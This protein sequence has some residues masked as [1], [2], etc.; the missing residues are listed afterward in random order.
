[1]PLNTINAIIDKADQLAKHWVDRT[2][3]QSLHGKRLGI[4]VDDTGW[5]Y[6]AAFD[7]SVKAMGGMSVLPI[8]GCTTRF[9][10]PPIV[11]FSHHFPCGC[12]F[13]LGNGELLRYKTLTAS[14]PTLGRR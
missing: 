13:P 11:S 10:T 3:P 8:L 12:K 5:R 7:V 1:M 4:V 2:M 6:T 9:P 14:D